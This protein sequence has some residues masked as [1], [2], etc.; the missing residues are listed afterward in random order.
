MEHAAHRPLLHG[1]PV[2]AK[3]LLVIAAIAILLTLVLVFFPWDTLR[4]SVNRYVSEKTGR[5]FAITRRLD[6]KL[7]G[8]TRVIADGIEFANP[9]WAKDPFLVKAEGGEI[10]IR[11]WPLIAHRQIVMPRIELRKPQLGLQVQEDGSRTWALGRDT[12]DRKN[13][14]DIG[15]LVVDEGT[16]H[17]VAPA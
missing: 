7:G 2:W 11:L 9:E 8:T 6:V 5:H 15:A 13:V 1:R 3:V 14:P 4:G 17:F 16:I 12:K 10:G